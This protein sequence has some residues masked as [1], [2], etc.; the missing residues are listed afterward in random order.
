MFKATFYKEWIK[1]RLY[2]ALLLA[3]NLGFAA[4]LSLRLR[5]VH[6][7][8]SAVAIWGAWIF[9]GYLFF[10]PYHYAPLVTGI[11][12]GALQFLPEIFSKRIRLVLHLPLGEERVVAQHLLAGLLLLTLILAPVTALFACTGAVYFPAEFQR[13][14]WL[15]LSPWLLAGYAA[16]L[17]TAT[18]LLETTWRYRISHLL[19][20]AAALR[21]FFLG[22]FYDTY[23][24]V[25]PAFAF[26]TLI[27]FS[28]PLFSSYR[29]RKGL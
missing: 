24:R 25:L 23:L 22:E 12:I 20:G 28:L 26:W 15:T 19:L 5:A 8:N 7:F 3:A 27:L 13:N 6:E 10:D 29:F 2:W 21:L 14:L 11:L 17:L 18:L 9:K 4:Y 16:Y 1:L